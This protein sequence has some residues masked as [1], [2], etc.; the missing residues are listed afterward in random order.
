MAAAN[1]Q[2]DQ[3]YGKVRNC[4]KQH[5]TPN[6]QFPQ[7]LDMVYGEMRKYLN[8]V[9]GLGTVLKNMKNQKMVDYSDPFIKD[10]T[11]ITL[12]NEWE[13]EHVAQGITYD[14]IASE[15]KGEE[16]SHAKVGGW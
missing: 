16:S 5:G 9:G 1:I 8:A 2:V 4:I 11:L 7:D 14:N 10:T 12:I 6:P 15:V 3:N 13:Q